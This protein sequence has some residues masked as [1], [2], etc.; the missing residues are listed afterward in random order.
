MLCPSQ[1]DKLYIIKDDKQI[2]VSINSVISNN[3]LTAQA[4][5]VS[6]NTFISTSIEGDNLTRFYRVNSD[7][8][9]RNISSVLF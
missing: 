7:L 4:N 5:L 8:D 1:F 6:E 3:Y 9:L 2:E